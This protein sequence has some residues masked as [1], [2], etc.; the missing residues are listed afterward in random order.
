[1]PAVPGEKESPLIKN[2]CEDVAHQ[3]LQLTVLNMGREDII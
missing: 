1:M 3:A 2:Y